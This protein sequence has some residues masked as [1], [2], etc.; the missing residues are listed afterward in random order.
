MIITPVF[1][2]VIY[3]DDKTIICKI[4]VSFLLDYLCL[5]GKDLDLIHFLY[6]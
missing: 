2:I 5:I 3:I 4:I 6:Y 1:V